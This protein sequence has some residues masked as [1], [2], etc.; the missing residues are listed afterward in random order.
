MV[1]AA[2]YE[3]VLDLF[4]IIATMYE[5]MELVAAFGLIL[6][7]KCGRDVTYSVSAIEPSVF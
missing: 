7:R 6:L 3:S 5:S 2:V 1:N 4:P